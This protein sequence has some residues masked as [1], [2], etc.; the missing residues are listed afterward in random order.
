MHEMA[1][2]AAGAEV[3]LLRQNGMIAEIEGVCGY[4]ALVS[5]EVRKARMA[6]PVPESAGVV[7]PV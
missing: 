3:G 1:N 4:F 5:G 7:E 6:F 2:A